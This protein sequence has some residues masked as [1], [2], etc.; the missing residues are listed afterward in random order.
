MWRRVLEETASDNRQTLTTN[1]GKIIIVQT[2]DFPLNYTHHPPLPPPP[3]PRC[4]DCNYI[5]HYHY[6]YNNDYDYDYDYP[7]HV[8]EHIYWNAFSTECSSG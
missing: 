1:N 6:H 3:P 2:S 8:I 7:G 5:Q 4:D